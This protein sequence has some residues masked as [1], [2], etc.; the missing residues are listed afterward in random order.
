[1]L[2]SKK[3][4]SIN[5]K[6]FLY[7]IFETGLGR[8][9]DE[10]PIV[11]A[12]SDGILPF[13]ILNN[14]SLGY[15]LKVQFVNGSSWGE[16]ERTRFLQNLER[17][18]R[19]ESQFAT[20]NY[21]YSFT[22]IR[23]P[24]SREDIEKFKTDKKC[25]NNI[26][27]DNL[28]KF[29]EN[30][31]C[32]KTELYFTITASPSKNHIGETLSFIDRIKANFD[33]S[34]KYK[35]ESLLIEDLLLKFTDKI[36]QLLAVF[37]RLGLSV[38]C[39]KT[40][41]ELLLMTRGAFRPNYNF[42][43]NIYDSSKN[44][45]YVEKQLKKN[46]FKN[47]GDFLTK[48][49]N[50]DL[51]RNFWIS[52]DC[53]NILF[54]MD[55]TPDPNIVYESLNTDK[56]LKLG[57]KP[58]VSNIPYF[59]NYTI[60]FSSIT[61]EEADKKWRLK[62]ALASGMVSNK[63]GIFEDKMASRQAR[64][65][66][67]MHETFISSDTDMVHAS[68]TY[69]IQ[70]PLVYIKKFFDIRDTLSDKEKIRSIVNSVKEQLNDIGYSIWTNE[71]KTY[72]N[73]W[74][75]T[76]PGSI[77]RDDSVLTMPRVY[78]TI[79]GALHLT[80]LFATVSPDE[81][82]FRGGNY[83]I[84]ED[85]SVFT[86]DHF[87]EK[88]GTAA[89]FSVCG[90]TGSGKSVTV[91]S[92]IMMTEPINPNIMILDFGGGNVGSWTKLCSVWGGV[93]LKFGS[94][95]P[96]RINPFEL[97]EVDSFPNTRKKS[98]ILNFIG[99]NKNDEDG[100]A[101]L[102]SVY[103]FLRVDDSPFMSEDNRF[104]EIENRFPKLAELGYKEVMNLLRLGPGYSL[105]GEKGASSIK[106]VL[107]LLLSTNVDE[108]GTKDNPWSMYSIDDIN[109]TILRLYETFHPPMENPNQWPTLTDFKNQLQEIHEERIEAHMSG[110]GKDKNG[111][112]VP[113]QIYNFVGLYN[114]ISNYC[115]GGLDPFL[116][117]QTNVDIYKEVI[118]G[119]VAKKMPAKFILAD[120]ANIS[121]K[122]KLAIYMIVIN[123]FMSNILYSS[124][125][126][127]GIMIRDEAWFFMKSN[128]AA[129]YLEADYRLARKYGFSVVTIAQQYSDFKSPVLQ[130]NTQTWIICAL[131]SKD[132]IDLADY[133]FKFNKYER[134]L[135]ERKEMGTKIERDILS[136]KILEAYSRIMVANASGKYFLK[137]K[138]G[139]EERWITTTNDAETFVFNYYK[140]TKFRNKPVI[141]IIE[142]LCRGEYRNDKDLQQALVKSGRKMPN[143]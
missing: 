134:G 29:S 110:V 85:S 102:D 42:G 10:F 140:E 115:I 58:G 70:I 77:R 122:R 1:M 72:F 84:T 137:N 62:N 117:G 12:A 17:S 69:Q 138:I 20:I 64:E 125:E 118:V 74:M 57:V 105:P 114:K 109:E 79:E 46:I 73:T 66:D 87:S 103:Q 8:R 133:R 7:N 128:I 127:K 47:A 41:K 143:I 99:L 31:E 49:L 136:G 4:K 135:F 113:E 107:E 40:E 131:T 116:D 75:G 13:F 55:E 139:K 111:K 21:T 89:N 78:T 91:Q 68:I 11:A 28:V 80:P 106:M 126:S 59:S 67:I 92:L 119:S 37:S 61:R 81:N 25:I 132:E 65:V 54:S 123:D 101:R 141:D 9:F 104:K 33:R 6:H 95:R 108:N 86:F 5:K 82:S 52:D 50:A 130:N 120:M 2:N 30:L 142:W 22:V 112:Y 45:N 88:N 43:K 19:L 15:I 51:Y 24:L 96:P 97:S 56:V 18:L 38:D 48:D 83:F 39:P 71:D 100:L 44:S 34:V 27:I 124:K 60:S 93:E 90:A 16:T 26:R 32:Q 53:L 14:S 36:K 94:A 63:K 35:A 3:Y 129:P 98:S 121:D 76:I 23:K